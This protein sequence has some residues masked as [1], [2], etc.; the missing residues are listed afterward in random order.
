MK[1]PLLLAVAIGCSNEGSFIKSIKGGDDATT[2]VDQLTSIALVDEFT[3]T[4][5]FTVERIDSPLDIL[6]IVD[7]SGS[8]SGHNTNLKNNIPSLLGHI[9]DSDWQIVIK[10]TD[11]SED[12]FQ[13]QIKKGEA[14]FEQK[15]ADAIQGIIDEG[16][17]DEKAIQVATKALQEK[18][19]L[20]HYS[21]SGTFSCSSSNEQNHLKWLRKNSVVAV[22]I[23][24]D[25]D[26]DGHCDDDGNDDTNLCIDAFYAQLAALRK[27][28]VT[29]KV[30]GILSP[31]AKSGGDESHKEYMAWRDEVERGLFDL[32]TSIA[33]DF[34]DVL[35]QI[36]ADIADSLQSIFPLEKISNGNSIEISLIFADGEEE[37]LDP[38]EY[39][40]ENKNIIISE[41]PED[42]QSVKIV[43]TY[44]VEKE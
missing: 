9:E 37:T 44:D 36:S 20:K 14:N 5:T 6:L 11:M 10:T 26:V 18:F 34:E 43:Y 13:A 35:E 17:G 40:I 31:N 29:A 8:M 24:S 16:G 39:Q 4:E 15:F 28:H 42:V 32:Y 19:S 23:V 7:D 38:D 33:G 22:L 3:K 1:F 41:L 12:C 2:R 30:Y 21:E 27:P 25:E